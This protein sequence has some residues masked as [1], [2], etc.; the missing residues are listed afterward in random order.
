[1]FS[2]LLN[3]WMLM[4]Q[5]QACSAVHWL[6]NCG[7]PFCFYLAVSRVWMTLRYVPGAARGHIK[8]LAQGSGISKRGTSVPARRHRIFHL[9]SETCTCLCISGTYSGTS[10]LTH[11]TVQKHAVFGL[12]TKRQYTDVAPYF[13]HCCCW[14]LFRT[15]GNA[16]VV[17][18][19][20][21]KDSKL[22]D[23]R[24]EISDL[25]CPNEKCINPYRNVN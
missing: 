2:Q 25:I 16:N 6:W 18:L 1:M 24:F 23:F 17:Y 20:F 11:S 13:D 5:V 12:F 4:T 21:K 19:S 3:L 15:A 14:E 10:R 8:R 22:C 7:P 9:I